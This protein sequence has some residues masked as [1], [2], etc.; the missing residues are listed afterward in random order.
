MKL[1]EEKL[2]EVIRHKREC[3]LNP[4]IF[5]DDYDRLFRHMLSYD[6]EKAIKLCKALLQAEK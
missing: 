2:Y 1:A 3:G 5:Y 4:I 6:L